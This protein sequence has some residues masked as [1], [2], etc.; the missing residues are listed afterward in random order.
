M[1]GEGKIKLRIKQCLP[2]WQGVWTD[3]TKI[4]IDFCPPSPPTNPISDSIE[5]IKFAGKLLK[6]S[7]AYDVMFNH[8]KIWL[9]QN[10]SYQVCELPLEMAQSLLEDDKLKYSTSHVAFIHSTL[11]VLIDFC[12]V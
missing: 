8:F 3:S 7:E 11:L 9:K 12:P 10:Y 2:V 6:K 5:T 1:I 4:S